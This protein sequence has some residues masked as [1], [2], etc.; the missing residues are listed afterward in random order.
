[1]YVLNDEFSDIF[2]P[3]P[4]ILFIQ[5]EDEIFSTLALILLVERCLFDSAILESGL[6]LL[7]A[8]GNDVEGHGYQV[9]LQVRNKLG[10]VIVIGRELHGY[11]VIFD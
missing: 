8:V 9:V 2:E 1:M 4:A 6:H 10:V 7:V 11:A 3:F 5:I